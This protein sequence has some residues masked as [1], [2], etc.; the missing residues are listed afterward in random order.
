MKVLVTIKTANGILRRSTWEASSVVA[1]LLLSLRDMEDVLLRAPGAGIS[2]E[3]RVVDERPA[4]IATGGG[5]P[6]PPLRRAM[7]A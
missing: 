1:A 3:G 2:M 6:Q 7:V 5:A 4:I